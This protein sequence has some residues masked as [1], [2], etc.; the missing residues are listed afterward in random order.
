MKNE[1]WQTVAL[2]DIFSIAR[3]GSPRPIDKFITE[4][5]DGVNW[6]MISDATSKYITSTKKRIIKEGVKKS[7]EVQPGDFLLTN[8]T[9]I[10]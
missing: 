7:R 10:P 2:G 1:K 5:S 3:G 6:I 9:A 4:T 8:S